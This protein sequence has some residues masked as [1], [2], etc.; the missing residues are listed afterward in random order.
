MSAPLFTQEEHPLDRLEDP[1]LYEKFALKVKK[2]LAHR[3]FS[4]CDAEEALKLV[5]KQGASMMYKE[6]QPLHC[7]HWDEMSGNMKSHIMQTLAV[8][9]IYSP[10]LEAM[11]EEAAQDDL[12]QAQLILKNILYP[13]RRKGNTLEDKSTH[14]YEHVTVSAPVKER[15]ILDKLLRR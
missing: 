8:G 15:S 2:T 7:V 10:I 12:V 14:L 6:L 11:G 5:N 9:I 3:F 1:I 4:I 13:S